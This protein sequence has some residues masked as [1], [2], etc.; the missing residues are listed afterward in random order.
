MKGGTTKTPG[1]GSYSNVSQ[2]YLNQDGD[3]LEI[4]IVDYNTAYAMYSTVMAAYAS[5]FEIDNTEQQIKGFQHSDQ[6]KG[7]TILEKKDQVAEAYVGVSD[8]FHITVKAD[9]QESVDFVIDVTT[10]EIPVD[11][12]VKL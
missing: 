12:L 5:G 8:R 1:L 6:V 11:E 9:N 3:E 7:W 4:N 2:K 10:E